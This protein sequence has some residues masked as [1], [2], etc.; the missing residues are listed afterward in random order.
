MKRFLTTFALAMALS[1]GSMPASADSYDRW[2]SDLGRRESLSRSGYRAEQ[3]GLYGEERSGRYEKKRVARAAISDE[4]DFDYR[5]RRT[6]RSDKRASNAAARK[7][8]GER[9]VRHVAVERTHVRSP[10]WTQRSVS[11]D[12]TGSGQSGVASYYWQ[13]QRVASGGWFNPNAMTAAHKTLPFG[14]RV[15]VTHAG[16]GRSVD[17]VINDRGPY[18]AGRIIDLSRAAASA[19]GMTS[20]GVARVKMMVLGR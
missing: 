19:I 4:E 11:R 13:G 5:P 15:R 17:V 3:R 7:S 16:S 8:H 18:V 14:T 2:L 6:L 9:K 12:T 1:A 20:Q 10:R